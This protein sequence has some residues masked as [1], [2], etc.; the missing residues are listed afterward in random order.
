MRLGLSVDLGCW[1]VDPEIA[2][3]V[4]AAATRLETAGAVV[5]HVDPGFTGAD[6]E[7]WVV[8][9]GVFMAAYFGDLVGE[10][11]D[12]MDPQVL[13]LIEAGRRCSAVDLKRIEIKRTSL[14]RRLAAVLAEHDALLCPTMAQP[15][16]PAAKADAVDV[17]PE[18]EYG[19]HS[20]D[21]TA[22][23]NLVSPCPAVSVP[24]GHH[25]RPADAGLPIG[26]QVVGRRWR[27]DTVLRVA[28]AVEAVTAR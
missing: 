16:W 9:W 23:F 14:W 10:F 20:P 5:E 11:G 26:L 8:L 24:C 13:E 15:P 12:V 21:M 6:E 17:P 1:A 3:A 25:Q 4:S 7:V 27:E 2:V 22:V 28:R 18:D 19:Y